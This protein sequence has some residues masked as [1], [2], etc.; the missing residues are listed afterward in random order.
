MVG[1]MA[2]SSKRAYAIPRSAAPRGP[3]L[4][5]ICIRRTDAE[6]EAPILGH[7]MQRTDSLEKILMLGKI[8]GRRRRGWQR[9]RWYDGIT[10]LM[11]MSFS[12][13]WELVM[14]RKAWRAAIH[15]V[16]NT[17]ERLNW[18]DW[19][20]VIWE[21]KCQL[22]AFYPFLQAVII[23]ID[24]YRVMFI[25]LLSITKPKSPPCLSFFSGGDNACF[26]FFSLALFPITPGVSWLPILHSSPL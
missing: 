20:A 21:E 25:Y 5:W 26:F 6:A 19:L 17:T 16:A 18:T 3:A 22:L 9:M 24:W 15:G 1:L 14:D 8:E 12:K 2:T 4:Y 11:D 7:L 13:L 10:D 23:S